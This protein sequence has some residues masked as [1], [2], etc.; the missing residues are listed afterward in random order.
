M[1]L[2]TQLTRRVLLA[3]ALVAAAPLAA[4]AKSAEI[5][6]GLLSSTAVG[7]Y[8]PVAYFTEGKPVTGKS[9][10][11]HNW[12]G[13]TWRFASEKNREAFKAKPESYAPQ[14]GG[15][16]AWA[17]S[18]GYTAKGDP[19]HWKV[20]D[21]RLYLN[22]DANVQRNWEKDIPGHIGNANRNWPK[23]LEKK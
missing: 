9:G 1:A 13:V 23:V 2:S 6:T 17:V 11:T 8:D 22:Y 18:Q 16:C 10:I 15:Y 7:G 5:Y 3:A 4:H 12:K 19:N 20:V 21:G 14:Y